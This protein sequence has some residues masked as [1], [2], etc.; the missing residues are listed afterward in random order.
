MEPI[1]LRWHTEN[2]Y[3]FCCCGCDGDVNSSGCRS[4]SNSSG[5]S[6]AYD[7]SNK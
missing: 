3:W 1:Y 7:S 6:N 5:D 2:K 4:S